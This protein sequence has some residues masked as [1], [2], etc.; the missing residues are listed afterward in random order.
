MVPHA[1][2]HKYSLVPWAARLQLFI[3]SASSA[4]FRLNQQLHI[5]QLHALL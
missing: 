4:S 5:L 1:P 3:F 2:Q